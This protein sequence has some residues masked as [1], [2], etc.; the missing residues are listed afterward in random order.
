MSIFLTTFTF[1]FIST[2]RARSTDLKSRP[3]PLIISFFLRRRLPSAAGGEFVAFGPSVGKNASKKVNQWRRWQ[4]FLP[5]SLGSLVSISRRSSLVAP[6]SLLPRRQNAHKKHC[7]AHSV[8][9][10]FPRDHLW[11]LSYPGGLLHA[12]A[13]QQ[14]V[15]GLAASI[16]CTSTN[17]ILKIKR[18]RYRLILA[19]FHPRTSTVLHPFYCELVIKWQ[20]E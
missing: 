12:K 7:A 15:S 2:P 11:Q 16:V 6:G 9:F 4:S 3:P 5:G 17:T 13:L 18:I 19:R 8:L 1:S 10:K 14:S 20:I